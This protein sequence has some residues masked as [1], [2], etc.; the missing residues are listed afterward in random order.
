MC[1]LEEIF[2]LSFP[3]AGG[4]IFTDPSFDLVSK[5]DQETRIALPSIHP[6]ILTSPTDREGNGK[7]R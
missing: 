5:P 3:A 2:G 6:S 1:V 7:G 4:S